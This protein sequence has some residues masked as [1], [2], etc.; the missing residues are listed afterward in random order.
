MQLHNM[1]TP[2]L[3][4]VIGGHGNELNLHFYVQICVMQW[5]HSQMLMKTGTQKN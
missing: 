5:A 4:P 2:V 1:S 3:M